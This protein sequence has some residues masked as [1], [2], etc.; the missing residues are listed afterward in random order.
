MIEDAIAAPRMGFI[1]GGVAYHH[2]N[3]QPGELLADFEQIQVGRLVDTDL[4]RYDLLVVPRSADGDALYARRYQI[5]RYLDH[6]GVL[7]A[8]GELWANWFPG[9]E[10]REECVEDVL[11][12]VIARD[13]PLVAGFTSRDLHWHPARE[14]WC[15]H[16]H[17]IAPPGAEALVCNQRGDAW[18]YIDRVTTNGVILAS[19]NLDPDTH[20]FHGNA[21]ARAFFQRLLAWARDEASDAPSRRAGRQPKIAG[22]YSGVHFQRAF[23]ADP[24]FAPRFA[25]LPVWELAATNLHDY[26]ALWIP[27]ESNQDVLMANRKQLATYLDAGGTIVCWDEVNQ[28][29][30]PAAAWHFRAADLDSIRIADHPMVGH[31]TAEQVRWHSHGAYDAYDNA[32]VL[33]DDGRGNVMLLLDERG[34]AGALLAGTLDPDCHAGFGT[35]TTRPLLH[36]VLAW[37]LARVP[38]PALAR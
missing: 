26:A 6:G 10:W 13:H 12:P 18:L 34:F 9:C 1:T 3:L 27:R 16:G 24:E 33:I 21:T 22:L 5:A 38:E 7:V 32:D 36:A 17:L 15:C 30:L 28:S 31:L 11:E 35:E 29:W 19:S 37:V 4:N 23:Y 8:F 25:V 14:R 20:T 2:G